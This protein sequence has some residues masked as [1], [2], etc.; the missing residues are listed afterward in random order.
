MATRS[1][2]PNAN[3]LASGGGGSAPKGNA[4]T[5]AQD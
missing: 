4:L 2:D 3:Q 5:S 1:L